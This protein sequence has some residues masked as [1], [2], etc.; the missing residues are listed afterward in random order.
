[1][2]GAEE[3]LAFSHMMRNIQIEEPEMEPADRKYLAKRCDVK[4]CHDLNRVFWLNGPR[5]TWEKVFGLVYHRQVK[6]KPE[7]KERLYGIFQQYLSQPYNTRL[8]K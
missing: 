2:M 8:P 4:D 1:M 7:E 5:S 3:T 6:I